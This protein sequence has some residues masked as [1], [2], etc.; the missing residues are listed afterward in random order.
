MEGDVANFTKTEDWMQHLATTRMQKLM[1][2]VGPNWHVDNFHEFLVN[3]N[4]FTPYGF[5]KPLALNP[6]IATLPDARP[7]QRPQKA[8]SQVAQSNISGMNES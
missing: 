2:K 8:E 7:T 1:P 5:Q 6:A 3:Y 4:M